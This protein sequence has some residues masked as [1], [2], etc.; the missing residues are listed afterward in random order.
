MQEEEK[1]KTEQRQSKKEYKAGSPQR[2]V[3]EVLTEI[4]NCIQ[5]YVDY[6]ENRWEIKE[7]ELKELESHQLVPGFSHLFR[8]I[9]GFLQHHLTFFSPL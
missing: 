3:V 7:A 2:L 9:E 5:N 4:V 1:E 6:P 8:V